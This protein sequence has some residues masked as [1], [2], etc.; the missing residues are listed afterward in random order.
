M[1]STASKFA[2]MRTSSKVVKT[3]VAGGAGAPFPVDERLPGDPRALLA[4]TRPALWIELWEKSAPALD[5]R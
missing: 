3:A 2:P 1:R 4:Q 5:F